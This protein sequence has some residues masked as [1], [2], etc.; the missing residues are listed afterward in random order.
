MIIKER[1]LDGKIVKRYVSNIDKSSYKEL[2]EEIQRLENELRNLDLTLSLVTA[3]ELSAVR[4]EDLI[5]ELTSR[6]HD[7]I[8]K[9]E[10]Y[11]KLQEKHKRAA[12]IIAELKNRE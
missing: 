12:A 1:N 6:M 8:K 11:D 10:K 3:S 4:T 7:N 2:S 9:A 5:F